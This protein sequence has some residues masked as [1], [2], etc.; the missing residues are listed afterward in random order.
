MQKKQVKLARLLA[1]LR[2]GGELE[3]VIFPQVRSR[4]RSARGEEPVQSE[5][6][7]RDGCLCAGSEERRE[8]EEGGKEGGPRDKC[9]EPRAWR[10]EFGQG[11]RWKGRQK[12]GE[13]DGD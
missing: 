6:F 7:L 3:I 13:S 5:Q 12:R 9:T 8:G 10:T 11:T 1:E 2:L 4:Q